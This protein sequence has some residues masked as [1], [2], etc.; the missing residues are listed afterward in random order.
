MPAR[1]QFAFQGGGAR[2]ALLLPVVQAVR[3]CE[4]E[5]TIEVTR[6][7]GTSAGAIAA[8]LVAGK[9]DMKALV[10]ELR[11]LARDEPKKLRKA[12]P[13]VGRGILAKFQIFQRV[14]LRNKPFSSEKNFAEFLET[15]LKTAGIK[16]GTPISE[17]NPPCTIICTD[18]TTKEHVNV[19]PN[20]SLLQ[21]LLDSTALPFIFRN[22]G[23]KLDGGLIDNLPIDHLAAGLENDRLIQLC[24]NDPG[25]IAV[26]LRPSFSP[27]H[28]KIAIDDTLPCTR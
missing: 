21:L 13:T 7:A 12:F 4:S 2:L 8:A 25:S 27:G 22:N 10:S 17:M 26:A 3:E 9:A 5:G 28:E 1:V 6:V 16:P 14:I 19:S 15:C 18:M 11:R 20:T 24:T 23:S